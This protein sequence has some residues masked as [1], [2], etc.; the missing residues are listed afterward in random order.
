MGENQEFET[1]TTVNKESLE[2]IQG[3]NC[4]AKYTS[5]SNNVLNNSKSTNSYTF[6]SSS[7]EN[8][9]NV[10]SQDQH[11]S[12]EKPLSQELKKVD[13]A[14]SP[15]GI[16]RE[17]NLLK[18]KDVL[19]NKTDAATSPISSVTPNVKYRHVTT[20]VQ[21]EDLMK[22]VNSDSESQSKLHIQNHLLTVPSLK[23]TPKPVENVLKLSSEKACECSVGLNSNITNQGNKLFD[24]PEHLIQEKVEIKKTVVETKNSEYQGREKQHLHSTVDGEH[25]SSALYH[26]GFNFKIVNESCSNHKTSNE[27]LVNDIIEPTVAEV[28]KKM[29]KTNIISNS[30]EKT[31][32]NDNEKGIEIQKSNSNRH[33]LHPNS[34]LQ[35][36]HRMCNGRDTPGL[37]D[38]DDKKQAVDCW[39]QTEIQKQDFCVQV[40]HNLAV[41]Q[42][43]KLNF[44][45]VLS[46]CEKGY[47]EM[48]QSPHNKCYDL[49]SSVSDTHSSII[50][51]SYVST[52]CST[53]LSCRKDSDNLDEV[54][55][56]LASPC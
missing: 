56:M 17:H 42:H 49:P 34:S 13:T 12:E 5:G 32:S 18:L 6:K 45:E 48:L 30:Q 43:D 21:I 2:V 15:I 29:C 9:I 36:C 26:P 31:S 53:S 16:T 23:L 44:G 14:T 40:S 11:T 3:N 20:M 25:L 47:L 24:I 46:N 22:L 55:L 35:T 50:Q 10:T 33:M 27:R 7:A 1:L 39:N 51:S 37:S 54:S 28:L 19:S 41:N 4:S 52:S 38:V 8:K